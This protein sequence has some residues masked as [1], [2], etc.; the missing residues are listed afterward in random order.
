MPQH[1]EHPEHP[2][3]AKRPEHAKPAGNPGNSG[4]S[5]SPAKKE[6]PREPNRCWFCKHNNPSWLETCEDCGGSVIPTQDA[7]GNH[8]DFVC[9][10]YGAVTLL[11]RRDARHQ[12]PA[13]LQDLIVLNR[14][15]AISIGDATTRVLIVRYPPSMNDPLGRIGFTIQNL[16]GQHTYDWNDGNGIYRQ[17]FHNV[18]ATIP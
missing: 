1:R 6:V 10:G 4:N 3:Q 7:Q 8:L 9:Y 14:N 13:R 16:G 5:G 15:A 11:P 2:E 12:Y 17:R 18:V